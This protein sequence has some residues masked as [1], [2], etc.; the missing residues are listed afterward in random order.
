MR[1]PLLGRHRAAVVAA[2]LCATAVAGCGLG[3][4]PGSATTGQGARL[5]ATGNTMSQTVPE[6]ASTARLVD[7]DG[8]SMSLRSLR[9]KIVVLAPL[10]TMCQE[11]C[12]LTSANIHRAAEAAQSDGG[13]GRVVFVEL[14]VDPQ[15]DTVPRLHAYEKLYGKLPDWRLAT[16][17]PTAVLGLWKALGVSTDKTK[18]VDTVRDWMGGKLIHDSYDVHHQDLVMIIDPAGRLRWIT[19][20]RPDARGT[21]L[22]TSLQ[23]FL[24]NEGHDNY[25]RPNAGGASS[26]TAEDVEQAV[27]YVR[28]LGGHS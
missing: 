13:A 18:P 8:H 16:G 4:R 14:T 27:A 3:D 1:V 19:T 10:L 23:K 11:T 25:T 20:G 26:W 2:L 5:V 6:V 24:N 17:K 21:R 12:P 7:Q 9:G 28:G 22:P 15:R